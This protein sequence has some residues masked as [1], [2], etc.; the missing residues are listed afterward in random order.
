MS[1]HQ[2]ASS[3][4]SNPDWE[5]VIRLLSLAVQQGAQAGASS[6]RGPS[7]RDLPKDAFRLPVIKCELSGPD[8]CRP[9]HVAT[10]LSRLDQYLSV[11]H[12]VLHS[13]SLRLDT[14]TGCF[15]DKSRAARWYNN[16]RSSFQTAAEFR[17]AFLE[18]FGGTAA[19]ER[20]CR[21]RLLSF[22]QR[23]SDTVTEYYAAFC[24]LISDIHAL[25]EFL[26]SGDPSYYIDESLQVSKFVQGLCDPFR[27]EVERLY[28]RNPDWS[29]DDLFREAKL[30]EMH[31]KRKT[32][33][34]KFCAKLER[35]E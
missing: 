26:H 1:A 23:S 6:S 34:K 3:T 25:A 29:L 19:D 7:L 14:I 32:K 9:A 27:V 17:T 8:R 28:V 20:T 24:D 22:R 33:Q 13:E 2:S 11:Y 5:S 4:Q 31:A 10:F 18:H 30:E 16:K 21:S 15:P 12:A 35:S